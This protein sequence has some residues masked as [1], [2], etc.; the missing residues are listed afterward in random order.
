MRSRQPQK[1][2]LSIRVSES[3][4]QHLEHA[5]SLL[6]NARDERV[7]LSDVA[8]LLLETAVNDRLD[9]RFETVS[10]R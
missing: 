3:L 4:R 9:H 10:A 2:T 5:R 6:A 1:S 7:S 8:K